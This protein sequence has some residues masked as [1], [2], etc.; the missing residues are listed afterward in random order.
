M[1]PGFFSGRGGDGILCGKSGEVE[2]TERI[3]VE[4][5]SFS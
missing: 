5:N 3:T 1:F 2:K 4:I